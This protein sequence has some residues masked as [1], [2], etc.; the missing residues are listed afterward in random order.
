MFYH[1]LYWGAHVIKLHMIKLQLGAGGHTAQFNQ[2][3]TALPPPPAY[4][5]PPPCNSWS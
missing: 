2:N 5:S 3:F 4:T 1:N